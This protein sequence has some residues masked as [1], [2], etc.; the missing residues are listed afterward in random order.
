[1]YLKKALRFM[2]TIIQV[3]LAKIV[4]FQKSNLGFGTVTGI[5]SHNTANV[6]TEYLPRTVFVLSTQ[7]GFVSLNSAK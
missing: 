2:T 5:D 4:I 3:F 6:L 1:M 7:A